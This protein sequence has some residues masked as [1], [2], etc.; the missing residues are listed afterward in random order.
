MDA[1]AVR[2]HVVGDRRVGGEAAGDDEADVALL[3][4]VARLSRDAGLGAGVGRAAKAERRQRKPAVVRALPT[5]NSTQ[6]QPRSNSAADF[7]VAVL[8]ATVD[9]KE[10]S[11]DS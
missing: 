6:S 3:E 8:V 10:P 4:H 2:A 9:I 1:V 11:G 5:Q 7:A